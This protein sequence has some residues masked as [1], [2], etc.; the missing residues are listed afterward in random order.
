M[1]TRKQPPKL[2]RGGLTGRVYVLTRYK[3][4]SDGGY[5]AIEKHDVT[6]D[7]ELLVAAE[8]VAAVPSE[9]PGGSGG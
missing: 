3:V 4:R 6:E 8:K 2:V 5:E 9:T 7:F 1:T